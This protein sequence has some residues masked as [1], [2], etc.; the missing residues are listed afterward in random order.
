M[1]ST[2]SATSAVPG[3]D[4]DARPMDPVQYNLASSNRSLTAG[5]AGTSVAIMTFVLFFLFPRW[6]S[7]DVNGVLFQWTLANIVLS[8]FLTTLSSIVYWLVMEALQTNHPGATRFMRQADGLFVGGSMLLLLEPALILSTV[9]VYVVAAL[10]F[11]LW[12]TAILVLVWAW[13]IFR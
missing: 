10:A 5:L 1:A 9:R 6:S 11:A 8:L 4:G 7:G 12:G 3:A 13:R 2:G